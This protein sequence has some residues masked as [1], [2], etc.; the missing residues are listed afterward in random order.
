MQSFHQTKPI[1]RIDQP[2]VIAN[3]KSTNAT[4]NGSEEEF[5]TNKTNTQ[6]L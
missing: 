1:S 3:K 4:Y 6:H 5:V 2:Y